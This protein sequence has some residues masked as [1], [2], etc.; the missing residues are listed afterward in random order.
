M[1]A[2][3]IRNTIPLLRQTK[4]KPGTDPTG[5]LH[6]VPLTIPQNSP[7]LNLPGLVT[8]GEK[9]TE[10]GASMFKTFGVKGLDKISF[11]IYT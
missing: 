4:I 6:P 5:P 10:P 11:T 8:C 9:P 1:E 7:G 3:W 2:F